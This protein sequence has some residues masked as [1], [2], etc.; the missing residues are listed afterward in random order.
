MLSGNYFFHIEGQVWGFEEGNL[1][2]NDKIKKSPHFSF[3]AHWLPIF[4]G[5][6][7]LSIKASIWG[8]IN[9]GLIDSHKLSAE[10]ENPP[11]PLRE[12]PGVGV[13]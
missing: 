8:L 3:E 5:S 7:V 9:F 2:V 4:V 6:C 12:D 11:V 1:S 13:L 10:L